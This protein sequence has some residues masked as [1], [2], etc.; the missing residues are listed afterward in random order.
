MSV[1]RVLV[2]GF[3][4][5]LVSGVTCGVTVRVL[6]RLFVLAAGRTPA[7]SIAGSLLLVALF[8]ISV[9]PGAVASAATAHPTPLVVLYALGMVIVVYT[10]VAIGV[11]EWTAAIGHGLSNRQVALLV[12]LTLGV[13]V[14]VLGNP[15]LAHRIAQRLSTR[16]R[17]G[18]ERP[19]QR[20]PDA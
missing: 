16:S 11:E 9:V 18:T 12:L 6:V 3:T 13:A 17:I 14:V 15:V 5:A 10:G 1:A 2:A 7:F 4:A 20:R 19:A 8:V